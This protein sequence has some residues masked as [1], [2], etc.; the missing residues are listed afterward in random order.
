MKLIVLKHSPNKQETGELYFQNE[1]FY[2]LHFALNHA[3]HTDD[4]WANARLNLIVSCCI[5]SL[6]FN[7][8]VIQL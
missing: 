4:L 2:H 3:N 1:F 8:F 6:I 5:L 7:H